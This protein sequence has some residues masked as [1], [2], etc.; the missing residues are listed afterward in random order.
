MNDRTVVSI[1]NAEH[2]T[3]GDHCDGY[4]LARTARL[5]VIQERVPPGCREVRHSH[6]HAEQFFHV[7]SGTAT[8]EV[9]GIEYH[10]GPGQGL[11]VAAGVPHQLGNEGTEDLEFLVTSTPPSHGDR[12][13]VP[14]PADT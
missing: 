9:D 10:L 12:I 11:H 7:L 8:L 2:Y 4:H 5:S 13:E 3:W 14:L 1:D 6:R